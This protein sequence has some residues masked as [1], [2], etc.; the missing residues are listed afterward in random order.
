MLRISPAT[1]KEVVFLLALMECSSKCTF[2]S[3]SHILMGR[4]EIYRQSITN[5][6][7][8]QGKEH[9]G[10]ERNICLKSG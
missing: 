6:E 5:Q 10:G 3:R 2:S 1:G 9:R 7:D 8:N 4:D